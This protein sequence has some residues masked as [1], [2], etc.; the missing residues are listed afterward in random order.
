M[1]SEHLGFGLEFDINSIISVQ[2]MFY[3]F[4]WIRYWYL[5]IGNQKLEEKHIFQFEKEST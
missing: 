4:V 1:K 5:H 3:G 2:I